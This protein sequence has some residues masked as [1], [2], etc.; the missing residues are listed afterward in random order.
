MNHHEAIHLIQSTIEK[1]QPL[2]PM[3]ERIA[4]AE[5]MLEYLYPPGPVPTT[6]TARCL[7]GR[8]VQIK[9]QH[10]HQTLNGGIT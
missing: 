2:I 8:T 9:V 6:V 1:H 4:I 5:E 10:G 3:H 7:C